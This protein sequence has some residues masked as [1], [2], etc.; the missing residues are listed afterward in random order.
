MFKLR[1]RVQ[2]ALVAVF[3]V[4]ALGTVGY[5]A[6]EGWPW[7]DCFY[8][9]LI[10]LSTIG[11]G[12]HQDMTD[13]ARIFTS[14]I[15]ISGVGTFGY[16][17]SA[18]AEAA[19]QG[20]LRDAWERRRMHD[21][22]SHMKDHVI[23]CGIGRVGLRVARGLAAESASFVVID[24]DKE[25]LASVADEDWPVVLGDARQEEVL[26]KAGVSRAKALVTALDSDADNV[27]VVLT[28]RDLGPQLRIVARVNDEGAMSKVR[29][30]GANEVVSPIRIGANQILQSVVRPS[31][32]HIM[33]TAI[34]SEDFNV[35]VDEVVV[36]TH[37]KIAGKTLRE[38]QIRQQFNVIVIALLRAGEENLL[39]NPEAHTIINAGD[40]I[41]AVGSKANLL[42]LAS[43]ARSL[44]AEA[45]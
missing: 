40:K 37:S 28:A 38:A 30:A 14:F 45:S 32:A 23:V 18:I 17:I 33:D 10:T 34:R 7:F 42:G 39:F 43:M 24:V 29:K 26:V 12:E 35:F 27:F 3:L 31:V 21:K 44:D 19:V 9:T 8:M 11:Y 15:I 5:R 4:F 16:A 41:I 36:V 25:R 6:L 1:S 20:S 13:R 2:T 22:I